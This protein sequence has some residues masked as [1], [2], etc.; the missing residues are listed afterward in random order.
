[1]P[2]LRRPVEPA[3]V[4]RKSPSFGQTDAID[5]SP[6]FYVTRFGGIVPCPSKYEA[7]LGWAWDQL[8]SI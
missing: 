4:D 5:P 1:M 2:V 8:V 6:T 3:G 7:S